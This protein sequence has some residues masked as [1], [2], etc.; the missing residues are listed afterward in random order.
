MCLITFILI[1]VRV[2]HQIQRTINKLGNK[3]FFMNIIQINSGM[4]IE[5][6]TL[7]R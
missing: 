6:H 5:K 3:R 1:I 2:L 7:Y 4:E